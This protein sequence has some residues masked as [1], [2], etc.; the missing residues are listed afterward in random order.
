M[1]GSTETN[2]RH[3]KNNSQKRT[4]KTAGLID[5]VFTKNEEP[6]KEHPDD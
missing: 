1:V 4:I 6:Y 3:P 5:I 2:I